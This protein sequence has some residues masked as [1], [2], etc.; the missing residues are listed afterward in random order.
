MF[1]KC[2]VVFYLMLYPLLQ[3]L[4]LLGLWPDRLKMSTCFLNKRYFHCK[5]CLNK[6][7]MTILFY[8]FLH[9]ILSKN[10]L[11]CTFLDNIYISYTYNP[12]QAT[13]PMPSH[14]ISFDFSYFFILKRLAVIILRKI[15][16]CAHYALRGSIPVLFYGYELHVKLFRYT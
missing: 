7:I 3:L 14:L 15:K 8:F 10:D 5:V 1:R 6:A 16:K 4:Q 12:M 2:L 9:F 13:S 11:H